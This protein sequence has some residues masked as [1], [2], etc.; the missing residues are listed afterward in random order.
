MGE[1]SDGEASVEERKMASVIRRTNISP[2]VHNAGSTR[3]D[4]KGGC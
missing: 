3:Q 1:I 4:K 2:Q